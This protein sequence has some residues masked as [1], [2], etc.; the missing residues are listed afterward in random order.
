MIG[1]PHIGAC[2]LVAYLRQESLRRLFHFYFYRRDVL[3]PII[4]EC[5]LTWSS[6]LTQLTLTK[7]PLDDAWPEL[8]KALAQHQNLVLVAEPGAGKTT[9]FPP[10]LLA[11][12]MLQ[13]EYGKILMLEPRRLAARAAASRIAT[14]QIWRL[15]HEVG[16]Q[17]RFENQTSAQTRI[18]IV[19]EG[20]LAGRL[21]TDPELQAFDAVILDEFHERSLHTDLAIGLLYEMQQLTRP[22]LRI[23]VMSATLDAER[24]SHFLGDCPIVCVPGRTF[25]IEIKHTKQPLSIDVSPSFVDKVSVEITACLSGTQPSRGDLL[26]FLP[27]AGEIR[28]VANRIAS[29]AN[30][31]RAEVVALHGSLTLEAQDLALSKTSRTKVILA[32][33]IAETSLTIDGVG[34]VIDSG[35]AR[36]MR[37]DSLGFPRLQ[38]SRI[39]LA[40]ATQR[41]GRS[42]R[43][44]P[45]LCYRLWSKLDE[46]SMSPFEAPEILRSDL[47]SALLILAGQGVTDPDAFS[48][49]EKPRHES[50]QLSQRILINIGLLD[51]LGQLTHLGREALKLPTDVRLAKLILEAVRE[52]Q[53]LLGTQIAALLGEK[54]ILLNA[55]SAREKA[56]LS[57][58][59]SD[60]LL[61]LN[62]LNSRTQFDSGNETRFASGYNSGYESRDNSDFDSVALKNVNRVS[63][64]LLRAAKRSVGN[65]LVKKPGHLPSEI[66]VQKTD[67]ELVGR[68]LL[69]AFP[70]RVCRRRRPKEPAALMVGGR[71]VTLSS[72][73]SIEMS[74]LFLAID[75]ADFKGEMQIT[76]ASSIEREW[77]ESEFPNQIELK[78]TIVYDSESGSVQQHSARTYAD[79][80]LEA[81][82]ISRPQPD[83]AHALLVQLCH[84]RWTIDFLGQNEVRLLYSRIGFAKRESIGVAI[85]QTDLDRDAQWP[86]L[87]QAQNSAIDE[88]CFGETKYTN[89]IKK[90][91]AQ[92]LLRHITSSLSRTLNEFA[93]E[94]ITVPSGSRIKIEYPDGGRSPFIEVRIQEVF[95]W[96]STP[97]IALGRVPITL[98]L[99]A[100]NYRPAQVTADL[101]SFWKNG[102]NEV[103]KELRTRY[104]KHSWPEDPL[105]ALPQAKGRSSIK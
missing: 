1:L 76:I 56:H 14:E 65:D 75:A 57:G 8:L 5:R 27:G 58:G 61:R 7:L 59:E 54:D 21:I 50:L 37:L 9:R 40:S 35:L 15:G 13:R 24:V 83:E 80:P 79:L 91:F 67:Q 77:L 94:T 97:R 44:G 102:Y 81:P 99:L 55:R 34:T 52:G 11:S 96:K 69:R 98:H 104:P 103:R 101:E 16:Y 93:P 47:S 38:L 31:H 49:F 39:S 62:L 82:L 92:I 4:L 3:E 20:L 88:V 18:M 45:G 53:L 73:S 17:V 43:Q 25:P 86:D 28:R 46:S 87:I 29:V 51:K 42:G 71:G 72:Q 68:I 84:D 36:V 30:A 89:I 90:P 22:D 2:T 74:D 100:P 10:L 41:A 19:T 12:N 78:K 26:V 105:T 70:D 32:T 64:H 66:S 33:N 85:N 63:E 23:I 48:W 60:V 95:G 6:P